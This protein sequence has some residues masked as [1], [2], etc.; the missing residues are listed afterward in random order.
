ML[1][2]RARAAPEQLESPRKPRKACELLGAILEAC[3]LLGAI[4]KACE[5]LEGPASY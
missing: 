5:L 4:W 2:N 1:A 3:E